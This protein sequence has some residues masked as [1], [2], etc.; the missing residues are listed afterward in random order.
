MAAKQISQHSTKLRQW[1]F[2]TCSYKRG[3]RLLGPIP[4]TGQKKPGDNHYVLHSPPVS[5][6]QNS[7]GFKL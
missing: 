5:T 1:T 7:R 6:D 3:L 2:G 4:A